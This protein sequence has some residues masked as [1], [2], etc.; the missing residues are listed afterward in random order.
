MQRMKKA[1]SHGSHKLHRSSRPGTAGSTL[2][3]PLLARAARSMLSS[4]SSKVTGRTPAAPLL[5][6][7]ELEVTILL[8]LIL[9][10]QH[11][12]IPNLYLEEAIFGEEPGKWVTMSTERLP[13]AHEVLTVSVRIH[14]EKGPGSEP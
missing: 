11:V 14:E 8:T 10:T 12:L 5:R 6:E 9:T 2:S 4:S 1:Q 3:V 7:S 13:M